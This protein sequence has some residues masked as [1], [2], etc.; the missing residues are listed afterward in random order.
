MLRP[1]SRAGRTAQ[2]LE[3]AIAHHRQGD[4][5]QAGRLYEE[6]LTLDPGNGAALHLLGLLDHQAGRLDEAELRIRNA[7]ARAP[8]VPEFHNSLGIVLAAAGRA[9]E[10]AAAYRKAL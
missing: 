5:A 10:A 4:F 3:T 1:V 8:R 9:E 6:L 2:L 7:I